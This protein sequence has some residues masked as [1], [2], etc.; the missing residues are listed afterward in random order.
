MARLQHFY[1]LLSIARRLEDRSSSLGLLLS[2]YSSRLPR[3]PGLRA[4]RVL[5]PVRVAACGSV[6]TLLLR[7]SSHDFKLV[8]EIFLEHTYGVDLPQVGTVLDLGAN[9]GVAT[10]YLNKR[11]PAAAFCCV[12]P[13]P[14]N[15]VVLRRTIDVNKVNARVVDAA[16][17]VADGE[18]TLQVSADP[19]SSSLVPD[20][21][22]TTIQSI[23]V[24]MMSV[25]SILQSQGWNKID[26]LKVDI[27]GYERT[28][29]GSDAGWLKVV[30]H[31]VGEVHAHVHYDLPDL[32]RDLG[33]YGFEC[34]ITRRMEGA[35][36]FEASRR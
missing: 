27:E 23:R 24:P 7:P 32:E 28:L 36:M 31:I 30:G 26:L 34:R 8:E 29:F 6:S 5:F 15:A 35:A 16:V 25:Q 4:P 3:V 2:Y 1:R 12:E 13:D 18:C 21:L 10:A 9:I 11:F 19:R 22:A 33:P 17:G 20:A 14:A